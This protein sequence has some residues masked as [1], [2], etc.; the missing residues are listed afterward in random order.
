VTPTLAK[1]RLLSL[2]WGVTNATLRF[3]RVTAPQDKPAPGGR[4]LL[5]YQI[6][7]EHLAEDWTRRKVAAIPL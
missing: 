2:P 5:D 1:P 6:F 4:E 3:A 7:R